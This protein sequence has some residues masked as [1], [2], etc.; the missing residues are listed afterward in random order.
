MYDSDLIDNSNTSS[1]AE[2]IASNAIGQANIYLN[3]YNNNN[4]NYINRLT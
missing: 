2:L 4:D 1:I 3:N